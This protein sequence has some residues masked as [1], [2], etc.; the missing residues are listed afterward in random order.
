M[1]DLL[2]VRSTAKKDRGQLINQNGIPILQVDL[3]LNDS[4]A[5]QPRGNVQW[6]NS[7][8]CICTVTASESSL[9][10]LYIVQYVVYG[11]GVSRKHFRNSMM[12][13]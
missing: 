4:P 2:Q 3:H 9:P 6:Q 11:L 10:I 7:V 1:A 8:L 13:S 5:V 12:L